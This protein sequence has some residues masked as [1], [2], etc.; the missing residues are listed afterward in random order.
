LIS[1][2]VRIGSGGLGMR[3]SIMSLSH[4]WFEL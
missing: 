1:S 4:G 2:R 3:A